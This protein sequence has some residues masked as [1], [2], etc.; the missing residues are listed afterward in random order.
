MNSIKGMECG[1]Q[2]E[3]ESSPCEDSQ[4][5]MKLGLSPN[6]GCI[7]ETEMSASTV[8][9]ETE[10]PVQIMDIEIPDAPQ[11]KNAVSSEDGIN[12]F[13]R[14][15]PPNSSVDQ[16]HLCNSSNAMSRG[17]ELIPHGQEGVRIEEVAAFSVIIAAKEHQ[18][19]PGFD[20]ED[21]IMWD[22]VEYEYDSCKTLE[23]ICVCA[24]RKT[25]WDVDTV[26]FVKL[27]PTDGSGEVIWPAI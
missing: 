19:S 18:Y 2:A 17:G 22:D 16:S 24:E 25:L 15:R 23:N 27:F 12:Q 21:T 13:G 26:Q 6:F 14:G 4:E 3:A 9:L 7:R 1:Q 10:K 20:G 8:N 5:R 11:D